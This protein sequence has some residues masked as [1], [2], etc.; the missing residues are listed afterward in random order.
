MTR[1]AG[2]LFS[3]LAVG[4][5]AD[6]REDALR[7][8]IKRLP[9][10]DQEFLAKAKYAGLYPQSRLVRF[11][12]KD[13][14][15]IARFT[16]PDELLKQFDDPQ[17]LLLSLEGTSSVWSIHRRKAGT[18]DEGLSQITLICF[19]P[20]EPGP[21]NRFTLTSDGNTLSLGAIQ[22]F[23]N[24][25]YLQTLT[26]SQG[27]KFLHLTWR[28]AAD[29]WIWRKL[30]VAD[31]RQLPTRVPNLMDQ[32]LLPVLYKMGPARP[33]SDVY[34]VFDQVPPDPKVMAL[35]TPWVGKLDSPDSAE[36]DR[37]MKAIE[38][39]GRAGVLATM[40]LDGSS[41]TPEQKARLATYYASEGWYHVAEVASARKDRIFLMA[42]T[43]DE[44][45]RVRQ[46]ATQM[47]A[48]LQMGNT[49]K[50]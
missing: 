24:Q 34:R 44:D 19:S 17:P 33:A 15:F 20:D 21:F 5:L 48:A 31:M 10:T 49:L 40:N 11:S 45:P 13:G 6:P 29:T 35:V 8:L 38:E 41:M 4:V 25:A 16:L 30:D 43:D 23:G 26:V 36:R 39:A 3:L 7:Q 47:L 22:M 14:R 12:N 18:L 46:A 37:A 32:Y 42:C 1:F 9:P 2:M 50:R 28:L 27:E